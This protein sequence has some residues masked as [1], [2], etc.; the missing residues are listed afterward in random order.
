MGLVGL[1]LLGAASCSTE[2]A[3]SEP[4]ETAVA[5]GGR[6]AAAPF[7]PVAPLSYTSKVKNLLTGQAVSD[8]E[9]AAVNKDPA[10][11]AGLIEGG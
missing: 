9:A 5:A 10:A 11:L 8:E 7:Q 3:V 4:E 2:P 6:H 1:G